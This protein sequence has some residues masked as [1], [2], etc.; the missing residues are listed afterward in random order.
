MNSMVAQ[1][2]EE[3]RKQQHDMQRLNESLVG[4]INALNSSAR[5]SA[6]TDC[7][8]QHPA[9]LKNYIFKNDTREK[10]KLIFWWWKMF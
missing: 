5:Q 6:Q 8:H 2:M 1:Q 10:L 7:Q 4:T 9:D 3:M